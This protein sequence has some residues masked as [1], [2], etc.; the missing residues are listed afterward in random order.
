[1]SLMLHKPAGESGVK[2]PPHS[3][4]RGRHFYATVRFIYEKHKKFRQKGLGKCK[5]LN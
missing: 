2:P 3:H 5:I 4:A 1:M